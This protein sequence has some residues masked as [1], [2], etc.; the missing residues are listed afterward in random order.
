MHE[1][2]GTASL[3]FL[4]EY[5]F[6]PAN[7]PKKKAGTVK[8]SVSNSNPVSVRIRNKIINA[9]GI[10]IARKNC[11]ENLRT[12]DRQY[13]N[14]ILIIN[15]KIVSKRIFICNKILKPNLGKSYC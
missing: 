3:C 11:N 1:V 13:P 10:C 12:F 14:G 5:I 7:C 8:K 4:N 15:A 9:T 6:D 2:S